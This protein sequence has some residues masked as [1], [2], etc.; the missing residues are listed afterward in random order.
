MRLLFAASLISVSFT[1]TALADDGK[2]FLSGST[3]LI[4]IVS[5]AAEAFTQQYQTW[6][7]FDATL[8]SQAIVIETSGGG[9]GQGVRAVLDKVADA[10]MVARDLRPQE[11]EAMGDHQVVR[12]GI[13]AVA[14]AARHDNPLHSIHDNLDT[15]TL[16]SIFS[17][18]VSRYNQIDN[19]LADQEVVLLVRDSSAGSAVM[20]QRQILGETPVSDRALQMSSQGQ[21]LRTLLG[22]PFTFAY[23]SAG[24]VNANEELKAF[25]LNGVAPT[26]SNVVSGDYT[27]AR[28]LLIVYQDADNAYLDAFMRYLLSDD[29]QKVVTD[30]GYI[31]VKADQ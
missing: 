30:L 18:E 17:G 8:P 29:G 2:L 12:V 19:N 31:P 14:I 22:N 3:T 15:D 20:L 4:P 21:L 7:Q 10:G 24:L 28:P 1:S 11:V 5:N 13:D 25:A 9:S 27:L 23:I 16:K 26:Q 6:D